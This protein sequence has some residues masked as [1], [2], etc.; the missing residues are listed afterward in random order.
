ML[1]KTVVFIFYTQN[2]E[3]PPAKNPGNKGMEKY[4]KSSDGLP[5]SPKTKRVEKH[6]GILPISTTP[7]F[8]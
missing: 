2:F 1:Q 7:I 5:S 4:E 6:F 8:F 3:Q